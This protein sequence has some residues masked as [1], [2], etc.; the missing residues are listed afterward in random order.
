MLTK[1]NIQ[2]LQS[3][4]QHLCKRFGKNKCLRNKGVEYEDIIAVLH[5]LSSYE[6]KA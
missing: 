4:D 3:R 6:I 1:V 2:R 5:N